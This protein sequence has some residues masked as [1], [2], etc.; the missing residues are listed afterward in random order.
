MNTKKEKDRR[1]QVRFSPA[2]F[3]QLPMGE[4]LVYLRAAFESLGSGKSVVEVTRSGAR[5]GPRSVRL[6]SYIRLLSMAGFERLTLVKKIAYLEYLSR[7]YGELQLQMRA[8]LRSSPATALP[9]SSVP[10][11]PAP[12]LAMS[13]VRKPRASTA[14]TA[15]RMRSSPSRSSKE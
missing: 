2:K 12:A 11:V 8:Y 6:P 10:T 13:A 3:R 5:K 14:R 15:R 9:I 7:A 4:K 1:A